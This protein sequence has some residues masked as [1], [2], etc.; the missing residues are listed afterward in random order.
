MKK[1][2]ESLVKNVL[3]HAGLEPEDKGAYF[4]FN[5]PSC[6][7]REAFNYKT[8]PLLV[9]SRRDKCGYSENIFN[10]IKQ[11]GLYKKDIVKEIGK[12]DFRKEVVETSEEIEL[13]E[14]LTF[15]QEKNSGL[16][17]GKAFKY[18]KEE[19]ALSED[20]IYQL[21]YVYNPKGRYGFS[22]FIPF[23]EDDKIVYFITRS[24]EKTSLRYNNP[25]GIDGNNFVFNYDNIPYKGN[26]FIFEGVFDAMS[27]RSQVG[28]AM[29]TNSLSITQASKILERAPKNIIFVPDNDEAGVRSVYKN[30]NTLMFYR[31]PSLDINIYIYN[32]PSKKDF[33]DYSKD[34]GKFNISLDECELYDGRIKTFFLPRR[35]P[36]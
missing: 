23:Y 24:L 7:H 22:I 13:P 12:S 20:A 1:V 29:L 8:S 9:C 5:C 34:S 18:L 26:I 27:L 17:A 21:G 31:P 2:S 33:N 19:R 36:I 10:F 30:I 14:G 6:G 25:K 35:S 28:T 32:I 4:R 11:E 16:I 3:E 15:F